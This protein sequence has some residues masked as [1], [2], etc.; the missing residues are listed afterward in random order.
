[1]MD[2]S[3]VLEL[4]RQLRAD[5]HAAEVAG[6][7]SRRSSELERADSAKRYTYNKLWHLIVGGP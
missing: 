4:V 1:M 5:P 3:R 7:L 2:D 6:E